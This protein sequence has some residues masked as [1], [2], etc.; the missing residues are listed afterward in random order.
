MSR[1][2]ISALFLLLLSGRV[3]TQEVSLSPCEAIQLLNERTQA[4]SEYLGQLRQ[5]Y[6]AKHPD[7]MAAEEQL[8]RLEAARASQ[9]QSAASRGLVCL[10]NESELQVGEP[11]GDHES[12]D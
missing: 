4:A 1:M 10:T 6:P 8:A 9:V 3:L 2:A 12:Q 5:L 11:R 7:V